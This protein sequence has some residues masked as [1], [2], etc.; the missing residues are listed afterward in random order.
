MYGVDVELIGLLI[1]SFITA[2]NYHISRDALYP[3]FVY[4]AVWCFVFIIHILTRFFSWIDIYPLSATAIFVFIFGAIVFS[5][6]G[7]I[8]FSSYCVKASP[9]KMNEV[10]NFNGAVNKILILLPILVLPIMLV[11]IYGLVKIGY[12][13]NFF[14]KLK[15]ADVQNAEHNTNSFGW[16]GWV[17]AFSFCNV[18]IQSLLFKRVRASVNAGALFTSFLVAILY[19]LA[20][21]GK[22]QIFL[23]VIWII[24]LLALLKELNAKKILFFSVFLVATFFLVNFYRGVGYDLTVF[25]AGKLLVQSF[26]YYLLGGVNAFDYS[27]AHIVNDTDFFGSHVFRIVYVK[28]FKLGID[29]IKPVGIYLPYVWVPFPTNVYTVYYPYM[30]DFGIFGVSIFLFLFGYTHTV[31]YKSAIKNH[32][33][34]IL[35]CSLLYFPLLMTVFHDLYFYAFSFWMIII[36]YLILS[37]WLLF[38]VRLNKNSIFR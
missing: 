11:K 32:Y 38:K 28:L 16:L 20:G 34:A 10:E 6:G 31:V 23:I 1:I 12:G 35:I 33:L 7:V 13:V 29:T 4:G 5:V 15:N 24:F 27:I 9:I 8:G 14:M 19:G 2:F 18:A 30:Q 37:E 26:L 21:G 36:S 3:P 17:S 22:F 25:A